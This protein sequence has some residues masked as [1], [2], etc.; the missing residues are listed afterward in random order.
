MKKQKPSDVLHKYT[1][2]YIR[3]TTIDRWSFN[4]KYNF[5][6][7]FGIYAYKIDG[8]EKTIENYASN[9]KYAHIL[10]FNGNKLDLSSYSEE[11]F[12]N[13][14]VKLNANDELITKAKET[15]THN[16]PAGYLWNLTRLIAKE[17]PFTWSVI[18]KQLGYDYV[19][20]DTGLIHKNEKVQAVCLIDKSK[21][22]IKCELI[23]TFENRN[24]FKDIRTYLKTKNKIPYQLLVDNIENED[25]IVRRWV[26]RNIDKKFLYRF[27]ND[28]DLCIREFLIMN[29]DKDYLPLMI[30]ENDDQHLAM[31]LAVRI[32]EKYYPL[33][34]KDKVEF[35]RTC[36]AHKIGFEYLRLLFNDESELVRRIALERYYRER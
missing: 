32:D 17:K 1:D 16:S 28:E 29:I 9:Y 19:V 25:V 23:E 31:R 13:D 5:N 3:F 24:L 4:P 36:V 2:H 34:I 12:N 18:L 15:T 30:K 33:L 22:D 6:T 21:C 26:V 8:L 11:N 10:K 7:P 35:V 14:L 20:D 27:I